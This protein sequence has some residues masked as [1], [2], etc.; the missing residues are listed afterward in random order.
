M[1]GRVGRQL[2]TIIIREPAKWNRL[3]TD[4]IEAA[5]RDQWGGLHSMMIAL[6][7][8][9]LPSELGPLHTRYIERLE[10]VQGRNLADRTSIDRFKR[11]R[12][13]A[14]G[15]GLA[16]LTW[17]YVAGVTMMGTLNRGICLEIVSSTSIGYKAR[18]HVRTM[19]ERYA[20][21]FSSD[22]FAAD[23]IEA[24]RKVLLAGMTHHPMSFEAYLIGCIQAKSIDALNATYDDVLRFSKGPDSLLQPLKR[25]FLDETKGVVYYDFIPIRRTAWCKFQGPAQ[26]PSYVRPFHWRFCVLSW[27]LWLDKPLQTAR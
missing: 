7:V 12:S 27:L 24:A 19:L 6:L 8:A 15:E 9:G 26:L 22:A 21:R 13:R 4:A 23:Y 20:P 18:G 1:K 3:K 25:G 16:P 14:T 17:A 2:T 5:A 11:V 10:Q